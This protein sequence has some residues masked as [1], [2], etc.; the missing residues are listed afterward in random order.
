MKKYRDKYRIPGA[1]WAAWNY[2]G[3]AAYFITCENPQKCSD[4]PYYAVD[5]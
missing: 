5:K 4:D 1:R 2:P 3:N